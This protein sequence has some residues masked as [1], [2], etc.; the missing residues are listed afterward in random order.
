MAQSFIPRFHDP[1]VRRRCE[2]AL[3]FVSACFHTEHARPA[4]R[5]WLDRRLGQAHNPVSAWLRSNLLVCENDTY[6]HLSGRCKTYRRDTSGMEYVRAG[7]AGEFHGTRL[8]WSQQR[9]RDPESRDFHA[10]AVT[11]CRDAFVAELESLRFEYQDKSDR[12]WHPLQFVRRPIKVAIQVDAG[13]G[14]H[15][16]IESAALTLLLQHS[17]HIPLEID[18][19]GVY[20]RGPMDLWLWG[21]QHYLAHKATCRQQWARDLEVTVPQ[22]KEIITALV[23]GAR[24]S[25]RP[26][27]A[28]FS[29]LGH[30]R[31]RL[32]ALRE[33][34]EIGQFRRDLRLM[35]DYLKWVMPR[36]R[37]ETRRG[38]R[39]QAISS[40][41][42]WNLYFRLER[43]VLDQVRHYLRER[44]NPCFLEHDGWATRDP[45][46]GT[47]LER[48]I[49]ITTGFRV[50]I[51]QKH[52]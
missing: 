22:I 47:D 7:L 5:T 29:M 11:W 12:L 6:D 33:H 31:A 41:D 44:Q 9:R 40:R 18:A 35:W 20:L 3:G 52:Y 48:H 15:Y 13:L 14:H 23:A 27:S 49:A 10:E 36:R 16:D 19:D 37:V 8:Q 38:P 39:W 21:I 24:I 4:A 45:I 25:E 17:Q 34:A 32:Q 2:Q 30:D 1:R 51:D 46:D 26:E 50:I 43:S 28:V 42:K